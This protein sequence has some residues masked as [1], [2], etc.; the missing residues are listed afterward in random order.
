MLKTALRKQGGFC[1]AEKMEKIV[2]NMYCD[3][4][5]AVL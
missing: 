1:C 5:L 2:D 4:K 3:T